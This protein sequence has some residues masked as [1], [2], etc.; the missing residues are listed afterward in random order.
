MM[1]DCEKCAYP[2]GISFRPDGKSELDPC[3]YEVIEAYKNVDVQIL[4]CQNCGH[5]EI[6]WFRTENT[7][8]VFD[9]LR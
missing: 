5:V 1:H 9:K 8:D 6:E 4:K 2:N 7:E 3:V